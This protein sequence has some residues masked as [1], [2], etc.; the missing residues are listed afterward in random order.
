MDNIPLLSTSLNSSLNE[1]YNEIIMQ[2]RVY[3]QMLAMALRKVGGNL[4]EPLA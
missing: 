3:W 2:L 1:I 4:L